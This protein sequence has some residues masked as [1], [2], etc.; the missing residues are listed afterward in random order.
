MSTECTGFFRGEERCTIEVEVVWAEPSR[1]VI[2]RVSV[3]PGTTLRQVVE[4]SGLYAD[5]PELA[6][7]RL[8]L[9][10]F[11]RRM[12]P[13]TPVRPGDRV[14]IYRPLLAD[15]KGKPPIARPG[16]IRSTRPALAIDPAGGAELRVSSDSLGES[17]RL[18]RYCRPSTLPEGGPGS[19]SCDVGVRGCRY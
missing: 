5:F 13:E 2:R 7:R 11:G 18:G 8:D 17:V 6:K 15:P 12:D 10:V 1:Q 4:M 9:G 16:A 3:A 14:E 19:S